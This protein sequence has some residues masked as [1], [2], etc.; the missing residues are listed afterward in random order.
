MGAGKRPPARL[1][2]FQLMHP[3][4]FTFK[5][6]CNFKLQIIVYPKTVALSEVKGFKEQIHM[7]FAYYHHNLIL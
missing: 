3:P 4:K 1:A 5:F 6:R 2:G 7:A